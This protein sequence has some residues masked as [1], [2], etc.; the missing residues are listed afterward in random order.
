VLDPA[1]KK[2]VVTEKGAPPVK[3][4]A[5]RVSVA[6]VVAILYYVATD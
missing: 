3:S 1:L 6:V 2:E 5:L 4:G